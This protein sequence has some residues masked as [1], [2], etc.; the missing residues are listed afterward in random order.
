MSNDDLAVRSSWAMMKTFFESQ[1]PMEGCI[2]LY[3][4]LSICFRASTNWTDDWIS[5]STI[6]EADLQS[7]RAARQYRTLFQ[8]RSL[9]HQKGAE[10][11]SKTDVSEISVQTYVRQRFG[12]DLRSCPSAASL[13][14]VLSTERPVCLNQIIGIYVLHLHVSHHNFPISSRTLNSMCSV[15]RISSPIQKVSNP[16]VERC[17][18]NNSRLPSK[19]QRDILSILEDVR[20]Y[21]R[22]AWTRQS[23]ASRVRSWS[24]SNRWNES[25]DAETCASLLLSGLPLPPHC[26]ARHNIPFL[27]HDLCVFSDLWYTWHT[28]ASTQAPS[29]ETCTFAR[30]V[31]SIR[32]RV[33][34]FSISRIS[35]HAGDI[36][37]TPVNVQISTLCSS[38]YIWHSDYKMKF[39][40]LLNHFNLDIHIR[41]V[42]KSKKILIFDPMKNLFPDF[43]SDTA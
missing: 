24:R 21:T 19:T 30:R 4:Q 29:Q 3:L 7:Q 9:Q 36:N 17:R 25:R 11:S 40:F 20:A 5:W 37:A 12:G 41:T 33:K 10:Q 18:V 38:E 6:S 1:F 43:R 15:W 14:L 31:M 22:T 16:Y 39:V 32:V 26:I 8:L 27:H 2:L 23:Y 35:S 42:I 28:F 34:W 13:S